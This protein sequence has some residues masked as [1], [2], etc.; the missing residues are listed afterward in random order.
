MNT[1]I[2]KSSDV[3]VGASPLPLPGFGIALHHIS[4]FAK[5]SPNSLP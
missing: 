5:L 1:Y 4:D 3:S 2:P